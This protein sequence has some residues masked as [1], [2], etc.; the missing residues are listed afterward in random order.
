MTPSSV[1]AA[2]YAANQGI[3]KESHMPTNSFAAAA[4][5]AN[6]SLASG[7]R[8]AEGAGAAEAQSFGALLS[9]AVARLGLAGRAT[10]IDGLTAPARALTV[11]ALAHAWRLGAD[12]KVA[13]AKGR[14]Q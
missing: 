12:L 6:Q 14:Q 5:A 1:A 8:R 2:A 10:A 3:S 7:I 9:G 13:S 4:Y 11:A